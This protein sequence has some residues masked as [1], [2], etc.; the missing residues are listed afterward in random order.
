MLH[1]ENVAR[2][3]RTSALFQDFLCSEP[4]LSK[5]KLKLEELVGTVELMRLEEEFPEIL[6]IDFVTQQTMLESYKQLLSSKF[7]IN[8]RNKMFLRKTMALMIGK[9]REIENRFK[10]LHSKNGTLQ[11]IVVEKLQIILNNSFDDLHSLKNICVMI[12]FVYFVQGKRTAKQLE[13]ELKLWKTKKCET[14]EEQQR[15]LDD[16]YG[17]ELGKQYTKEILFLL[18]SDKNSQILL[19]LAEIGAKSQLIKFIGPKMFEELDASGLLYKIFPSNSFQ[20]DE[21][22]WEHYAQTITND[23]L[24]DLG[25]LLWSKWEQKI[26]KSSQ[27]KATNLRRIFYL[28]EFLSK[29]HQKEIAALFRHKYFFDKFQGVLSE[30]GVDKIKYIVNPSELGE[31]W[32]K[33][34]EKEKQFPNVTKTQNLSKKLEKTDSEKQEELKSECKNSAKPSFEQEMLDKITDD[35]MGKI[36]QFGCPVKGLTL[37][38]MVAL[39][40]ANFSVDEHLLM[41][42]V[43]KQSLM[44]DDNSLLTFLRSFLYEEFCDKEEIRSVRA[45][46]FFASWLAPRC[47]DDEKTKSTILEGKKSEKESNSNENVWSTDEF[48]SEFSATKGKL[49]ELVGDDNMIKLEEQ[50]PEVL[51][52]GVQLMKTIPILYKNIFSHKS[53]T[54]KAKMWASR[55]AIPQIVHKIDNF[56]I[57]EIKNSATVCVELQNVLNVKCKQIYRN[58]FG[59]LAKREFFEWMGQSLCLLV[60]FEKLAKSTLALCSTAAKDRINLE[61]VRNWWPNCTEYDAQL[62]AYQQHQKVIAKHHTGLLFL[63]TEE[64]EEFREFV[65]ETPGVKRRIDNLLASE[66]NYSKLMA[67]CAVYLRKPTTQAE[68]GIELLYSKFLDTFDTLDVESKLAHVLALSYAVWTRWMDGELRV[69]NPRLPIGLRQIYEQIWRH[70]RER[71]EIVYDKIYDESLE[72]LMFRKKLIR[73][74]FTKVKNFVESKRNEKNLQKLGLKKWKGKSDNR[75]KQTQNVNSGK[76]L[77]EW[78]TIWARAS[79][80][81]QMEEAECQRNECQ[82]KMEIFEVESSD[83]MQTQHFNMLTELLEH[84]SM[85]VRLKNELK[86]RPEMVEQWLLQFMCWEMAEKILYLIKLNDEQFAVMRAY[87]KENRTKRG[88]NEEEEEKERIVEQFEEKRKGMKEKEENGGQKKSPKEEKLMRKRKHSKKSFLDTKSE[89]DKKS[90]ENFE[91]IA[92]AT[93]TTIQFEMSDSAAVEQQRP[94]DGT[95][96]SA[97]SSLESSNFSE[98]FEQNSPNQTAVNENDNDLKKAIENIDLNDFFKGDYLMSKY[99]NILLDP[100][101]LAGQILDIGI[102]LNNLA[103]S[104]TS[105]FGKCADIWAESSDERRM[106][107]LLSIYQWDK[108]KKQNSK[109]VHKFLT[110]LNGW[111]KMLEQQRIDHLSTIQ[112][113]NYLLNSKFGTENDVHTHYSFVFPQFNQQLFFVQF[114]DDAKHLKELNEIVIKKNDVKT[115]EANKALNELKIIMSRWSKEARMLETGSFMLGARTSN[116]DIDVICIVPQKLTKFEERNQ[117]FGTFECNLT[118]RKCEQNSFYCLLCQHD[119]V[120]MLQKVPLAFIPLIKLKFCGIEFDIL[121][122]SIPTIETLPSEPMT[123]SDVMGLMHKLAIQTEPDEKMIKSLAGYITNDH[124][125]EL[126]G[127]KIIQKFRKF[128]AI[129]KLWAKSNYLYNSLFGFFNG[130][131]LTIMATKVLLFYPNASV[132]FLL[133]KFFF[134]YCTWEWPIPVRLVDYVPNEFEKFSWTQK[135]EEDKKNSPLLMPIITPGCL[136][137]N[138]MYNMSKSTYQIVQ[139]SMQEALIK[140]R[141]IPSSSNWKQLFPMKKFTEKYE[142]FV[143]ICCIVDNH[144][145]LDKFCGFVGRRIR[146]QLEH[147]DDMTSEVK[148]SH[149]LTEND[150]KL[151]CPNSILTHSKSQFKNL[152]L[153]KVW[154]GCY[155]PIL[156]ISNYV[157][158]SELQLDDSFV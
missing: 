155:Q 158:A 96:N 156:L 1:A 74:V 104:I 65:R 150:G 13:T 129:L 10:K 11:Q 135:A 39:E 108:K 145:H 128:I 63:I 141:Q 110:D 105:K 64:N 116:S 66:E 23:K 109:M 125:M 93:T 44:S 19:L 54:S 51:K 75:H 36:E 4:E 48:G 69:E 35:Q 97:S 20:N 120:E 146:V 31:D 107:L 37:Q 134:T 94:S 157:D 147:F 82:T 57:W 67:H 131:S 27:K 118:L 60:Q 81:I 25:Q 91:Q 151:N 30:Y 144:I 117:F 119:N 83:W 80:R 3:V 78:E 133:H 111:Q 89:K 137:Q 8:K 45:E 50:F 102:Y 9:L 22:L 21:N 140:V 92:T 90:V 2:M 33:M 15:M 86:A 100:N 7:P 28:D 154:L 123:R 18:K 6:R 55:I 61:T 148:F 139:T 136:E 99:Q 153:H 115:D 101:K 152:S 77:E 72:E 84:K 52:I 12:K 79:L 40:K 17:K 138:G 132:P 58:A 143:A 47:D 59:T 122:V 53:H 73:E 142:H 149:I 38:D 88:E 85:R 24:S 42:V 112:H 56:L 87:Q 68:D 130:I 49:Y 106:L 103:N 26:Y 121:F 126:L 14:A 46:D 16:Y 41:F 76:L 95:E 113:N 114:D 71:Y 98:K 70:C 43:K 29:L 62:N 34:V 32:E 127:N 124:I 5:I